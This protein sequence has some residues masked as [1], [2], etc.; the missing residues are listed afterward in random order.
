MLHSRGVARR[1]KPRSQIKNFVLGFHCRCSNLAGPSRGHGECSFH[2]KD[3]QWRQRNSPASSGRTQVTVLGKEKCPPVPL[4]PI[5][6]LQPLEPDPAHQNSHRGETVQVHHVLIRVH[7]AVSSEGA[8]AET[9]WGKA[10]RVP[11]VFECLSVEAS[12]E[13]ARRRAALGAFEEAVKTI[14]LRLVW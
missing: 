11:H 8:H 6:V 13:Q 1:V 4:L 14:R 7:P 12:V 5:H 3:K 9:H 2:L 10:V